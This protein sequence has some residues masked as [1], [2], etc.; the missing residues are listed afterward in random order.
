MPVPSLSTIRPL[1][2][3]A[4]RKYQP[5]LDYEA[6]V[7][8]VTPINAQVIAASLLSAW[9]SSLPEKDTFEGN[10]KAAE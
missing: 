8:L 5:N 10:A 7:K 9:N 2:A 3:A 6:A 4:A 1:F